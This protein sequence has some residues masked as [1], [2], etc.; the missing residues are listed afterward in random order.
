PLMIL[1][2]P[3]VPYL[4]KHFSAPIFLPQIRL[5]FFCLNRFSLFLHL[6]P[7]LSTINSP[8]FNQSHVNEFTK[9]QIPPRP[10]HLRHHRRS[11]A[12]QPP[13]TRERPFLRRVQ[14]HIRLRRWP[15]L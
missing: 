14:S 1:P 13:Q 2:L 11:P 9:H 7:A 3:S 12:H 4:S 5:L 6:C 8:T 15:H 10:G